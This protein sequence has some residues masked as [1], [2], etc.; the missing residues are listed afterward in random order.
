MLRQCG[1]EEEAQRRDAFVR[2]SGSSKTR[3]VM[4]QQPRALWLAL[5]AIVLIAVAVAGGGYAFYSEH[6]SA[7]RA[8]EEKQR[9]E[10][11]RQTEE[12]QR[13]EA[14]RQ[15]EEKQRAEAA[16]QTEEKQ[17]AEAAR[18]T[19]DKALDLAN[20][21]AQEPLYSDS[22]KEFLA[23]IP[24]PQK[25]AE[26]E[27]QMFMEK[28]ALLATT[29]S[30]VANMRHEMMKTVAKNL[31]VGDEAGIT[32]VL[33]LTLSGITPELKKR[34]S[35]AEPSAGVIVV[36]VVKNSEAAAKD[37]RPG[38]IIGEVSTPADL[39]A[40]VNEAKKNGQKSILLSVKRQ[41]DLRFVA[42]H[43]D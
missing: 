1:G 2:A 3:I 22:E 19:G 16:R 25:R 14:A 39:S 17:R 34:F 41:H 35:L 31:R 6:Q 11:A 27:R 28:Q 43:P 33:G 23:K 20:N 42:L 30:N 26:A 4:R 29:L 7:L 5:A 9:A 12:K 21:L 18:Q 8:A 37:V 38:D 10:A 40:K 13:A 15:T 24:D 32:K 36:E